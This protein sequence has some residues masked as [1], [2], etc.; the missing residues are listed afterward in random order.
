[1]LRVPVDEAKPQKLLKIPIEALTQ[2]GDEKVDESRVELELRVK[3]V[4]AQ[5]DLTPML[6]LPKV[7]ARLKLNAHT[8]SVTSAVYLSAASSLWSCARAIRAAAAPSAA[9]KRSDIT[10]HCFGRRS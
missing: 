7:H 6:R 10:R 5:E 8:A 4:E 3:L 9:E 1:M 2:I